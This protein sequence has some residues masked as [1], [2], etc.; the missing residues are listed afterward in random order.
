MWP[1]PTAVMADGR[2]VESPAAALQL[3]DGLGRHPVE[4]C[5]FAY[6]DPEWRLLGLRHAVSRRADEVV[7][8]FR[9]VVR[10]VLLH[11]ARLVV[12]AHNHP[13]GDHQPSRDDLTVTRRLA[14]TLEAIGTRLIDHW[15]LADSGAT[16]MRAAGLL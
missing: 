6:L 16:S 2:R 15:V 7:L 1:T 13:R 9:E 10:D 3:F 8:P 14:A 12:M 4:A 5:A 11:D